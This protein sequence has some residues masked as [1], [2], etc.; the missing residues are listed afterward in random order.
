MSGISITKRRRSRYIPKY[1]K[2]GEEILTTHTQW[3]ITTSFFS[4]L[5]KGE[6]PYS[7]PPPLRPWRPVVSAWSEVSIDSSSTWDYC[8]SRASSA[9]SP[10]KCLTTWIQICIYDSMTYPGFFLTEMLMIS[11]TCVCGVD[12]NSGWIFV[13]KKVRTE[14][15]RVEKERDM[16]INIINIKR[17]RVA[18]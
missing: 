14:A 10:A 8:T 5:H 13:Y 9:E 18:E 3:R 12:R 2:E 15:A 17:V 4:Y 16:C 6:N 1:E 7:L 11:L